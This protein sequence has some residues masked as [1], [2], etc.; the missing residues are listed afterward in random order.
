MGSRPVGS[1]NL[2]FTFW[3]FPGWSVKFEGAIS[4]VAK[5]DVCGTG[6]FAVKMDPYIIM[7]YVSENHCINWK[8]TNSQVEPL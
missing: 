3:V 7:I 8:V 4:T 5:L 1:V 2:I 6:P